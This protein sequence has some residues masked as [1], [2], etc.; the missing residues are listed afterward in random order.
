MTSSHDDDEVLTTQLFTVPYIPFVEA[1]EMY[2]S[3]PY[4]NTFVNSQKLRPQLQNDI[5][6]NSTKVKVHHAWILQPMTVNG[7]EYC[8][9]FARITQPPGEEEEASSS[10]SSTSIDVYFGV[11]VVSP[12]VVLPILTKSNLI[13][14]PDAWWAYCWTMKPVYTSLVSKPQT[15][16]SAEHPEKSCVDE[17]DE[18]DDRKY[19]IRNAKT[20]LYLSYSEDRPNHIDFF[21]CALSVFT[22]QSVD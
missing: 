5:L 17:P 7:K 12:G 11:Q 8:T 3:F 20:K 10:S 9:I 4:F 6:N 18:L 2:L 22:I 19:V 13:S 15:L 21:S 1:S 14:T 16:L